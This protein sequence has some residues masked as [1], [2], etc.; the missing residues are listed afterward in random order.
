MLQM[1]ESGNARAMSDNGVDWQIHVHVESRNPIWGELEGSQSRS[2]FMVFGS[3]TPA[4]G[5]R[6]LPFDPMADVASAQQ[7]AAHITD[8]LTT[9]KGN[10]PFPARDNIELWLVDKTASPVA[11]LASIRAEETQPQRWQHEWR[12]AGPAEDPKS[13]QVTVEANT[14]ARYV[15]A[16]ARE[17]RWL[18]RNADGSGQLVEPADQPSLSTH[19][20]DAASLPELLLKT[21]WPDEKLRRFAETYLLQQAPRLLTLPYL[22]DE[23]RDRLERHAAGQALAVAH[24]FRLYPQILNPKLIDAARV[25]AQMRSNE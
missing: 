6:R 5:L 20:M 25:E 10:I 1:V 9:V 2:R 22:C 8:M 17:T 11:L 24:Y 4:T 3:W 14:L 7:Q 15:N 19:T 21:A 12:A 23:T 18:R 16:V 13:I